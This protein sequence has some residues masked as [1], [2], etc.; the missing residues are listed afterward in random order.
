MSNIVERE[1]NVTQR[2]FKVNERETY[3]WRVNPIDDDQFKLSQHHSQEPSCQ[4]NDVLKKKE[5]L[6]AKKEIL[7]NRR[8]SYLLEHW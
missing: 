3:L 2:E 4:C 7:L 6:L 5:H 8:E 1:F